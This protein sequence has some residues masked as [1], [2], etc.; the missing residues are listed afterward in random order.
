MLKK[1]FKEGSRII[2][3][4]YITKKNCFEW[5]EPY[6]T[7]L[8]NLS[9]VPKGLTQRAKGVHPA[10]LRRL[11]VTGSSAGFKSTCIFRE[12][13]WHKICNKYTG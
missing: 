5:G 4:G 13:L 6:P 1:Y 12:K 8:R 7:C 9:S 10:C 2:K 3:R 11:L